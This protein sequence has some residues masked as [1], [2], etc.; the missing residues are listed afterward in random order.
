MQRNTRPK[1][2]PQIANLYTF[3]C[4]SQSNE[5]HC[6]EELQSLKRSTFGID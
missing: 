6:H 5:L 3:T 4:L 2:Y 1:P